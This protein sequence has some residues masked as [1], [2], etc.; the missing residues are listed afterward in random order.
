M[1]KCEKCGLEGEDELFVDDS[2]C[3]QCRKQY[4]HQY[5]INNKEKTLKRTKQY[6]IDNKEKVTERKKQRYNENKNEIL[7]KCKQ[8]RDENK[9]IIAARNKKYYNNNKE[10]INK[11]NNEYRK[12]N[13]EKIYEQYVNRKKNDLAFKLRHSIGIAVN[14]IFKSKGN[15]KYGE[16]IL[17]YLSYNRE[18]LKQH[19]I[20]Q[21]SLPNNEWMTEKNHGP[22][23]PKTW[24]D[25]D[26]STWKWQLD[27]IIPQSKLPYD[28]MDHINFKIS[29]SLKNLRSYSAKQ[30]IIDGN[31]REIN[32]NLLREI[33]QD[34]NIDSVEIENIIY[35]IISVAD[36][37]ETIS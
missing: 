35:N 13:K 17:Q 20:D 6:N 4:K 1:K 3:K 5:Y 11:I 23:I 22:Y 26:K 36:K 7:E 9:E 19:I 37:N 2:C 24:D 28:S 12:K 10:R 8:Y 33:L 25:N 14:K 32:Q 29:W 16:S 18:I 30:N 21:F 15:S 34:L 31:N 27:H